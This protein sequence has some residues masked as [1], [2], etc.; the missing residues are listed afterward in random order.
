M[1]KG[2][3]V[4]LVG[5]NGAGKT[6]IVKLLCGLYTPDSGEILI[7]DINIIQFC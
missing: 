1:E 6:T 4:A 5:N 2:E 7:N 3:K